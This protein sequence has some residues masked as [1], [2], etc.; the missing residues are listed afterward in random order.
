MPERPFD[1]LTPQMQARLEKWRKN[2]LPVK[3]ADKIR[4]PSQSNR[5]V[6][7]DYGDDIS[8]FE[9]LKNQMLKGK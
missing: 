7:G 3:S 5:N 4:G 1:K 6:R 9:A 8:D 2:T